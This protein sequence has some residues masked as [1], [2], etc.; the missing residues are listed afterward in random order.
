MSSLGQISTQAQW[1]LALDVV[2]VGQLA[3]PDM[4]EIDAGSFPRGCP[5]A[6][7]REC[8]HDERPARNVYLDAFAIDRLEVSWADYRACVSAGLCWAPSL[9]RCWIWTGSDFVR[10]AGLSELMLQDD[11]PAVC[12]TWFE[13]RAYCK[14]QGKRLPSEAQ[15]ERAARGTDGRTYPWGEQPPSCDLVAMGGCG[16]HSFAVGTR[17]QGVSP[18]GALDMSGNVSEWVAD[19]WHA[20]A[21]SYAA[22]RNPEGPERGHVRV[23][24]GGSFYDGDAH[25]RTSYRYGIEPQGRLSTVGFRCVESR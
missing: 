22:L 19:W 14:A 23:V 15:W 10:G 3:G 25:L 21:Y 4:V 1:E 16:A 7:R 9:D 24:R 13:A 6:R 5:R 20:R 11:H 18:S 8:E 2:E 12:V 17:P